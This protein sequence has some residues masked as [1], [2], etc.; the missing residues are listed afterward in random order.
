MSA[1]STRR[2]SFL[3]ALLLF[4]A[5]FATQ[6]NAQC[7]GMPATTAY[8]PTTAYTAAYPAQSTGWYPGYWL[9]RITSRLFGSPSTYVTAYPTTA[10]Y[11]GYAPAYTAAY[12]PA[13]TVGYATTSYAAPM[14]YAAPTSYAAPAPACPTCPSYS[15]SYAPVQQVTVQSACPS[16]CAPCT[17]GASYVPQQSYS[18]Q[19]GA[20]GVQAESY[21]ASAGSP[22]C[23]QPAASG[24]Q[25]ATYT[26]PSPSG[27][28][29]TPA[30]QR[31]FE[32]Q[33]AAPSLD[34]TTSV[35]ER[36]QDAQRPPTND[37]NDTQQPIQPE[38][39][40]ENGFDPYKVEEENSTYFQAPKLFDPSDRTARRNVAPVV[41]AVYQKPADAPN[42]TSAQPISLQQAELDAMGWVSASN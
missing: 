1:T 21:G 14:S 18:G 12:R 15:A 32:A 34:P 9:Q 26:A 41:T 36:Q 37:A 19:S 29:P 4:A 28:A 25:P 24:A 20:Y 3:I 30:L 33:N 8:Y 2:V 16:G 35:P 10:Y 31:T 6:A 13:Y 5:P 27:P 22:S 42:S 23:C 7:C 17:A 11:A 40:E 39:A 38:P